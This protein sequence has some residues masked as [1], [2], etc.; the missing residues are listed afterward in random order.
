MLNDTEAF[1]R[2]HAAALPLSGRP[3]RS[4]AAPASAPYTSTVL[5]PGGKAAAELPPDT[6]R[7]GVRTDLRLA[8][9]RNADK[10][11]KLKAMIEQQKRNTSSGRF[12]TVNYLSK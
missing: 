12:S 8:D 10:M 4:A 3:E 7:R 1:T 6:Y 9:E 2:H 5:V 11:S